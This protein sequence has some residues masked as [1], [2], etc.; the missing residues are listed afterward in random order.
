MVLHRATTI[1]L[2][3]DLPASAPFFSPLSSAPIASRLLWEHS[4]VLAP[5]SA[6]CVH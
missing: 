2:F 3:S 6:L 5:N 4:C 1:L